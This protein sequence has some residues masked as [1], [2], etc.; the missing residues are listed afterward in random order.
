VLVAFCCVIKG[1][2]QKGLWE[3]STGKAPIHS[4]PAVSK[5]DATV[6]VGC[7]GGRFSAVDA[8][9]G[10]Q[11]WSYTAGPGYGAGVTSP[12]VSKDDAT[13]FVGAE[14]N[15]VLAFHT[16]NGTTKW[17]YN[18]SGLVYSSP[19]LSHDDKLVFIADNSGRVYALDTDK[20]GSTWTHTA[21]SEVV[22]TPL[23][24]ADGKL[25]FLGAAS[26]KLFALR[27][28]DGS[29][30]W[31]VEAGGPVFASQ[32]LSPDGTMLF[33]GLQNGK[34][35]AVKTATGAAVWSY[36]TGGEAYTPSV[37]ANGA[38][39]YVGSWDLMLHAV[40]AESGKMLWTSPKLHTYVVDKPLVDPAGTH[41]FIASGSKN[42]GELSALDATSGA[43]KWSFP[44]DRNAGVMYS[45][46]VFN[47]NCTTVYIG[48]FDTKLH[49]ISSGITC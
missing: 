48:A 2:G 28:A 33:A 25:L 30:A 17:I 36:A 9:T 45:S 27:S 3:F 10:S 44:F 49:A 40:S 4:T 38:T 37:S 34:L 42:S 19:T 35:V 14:N 21:D 20:G 18:T 26:G 11:K 13:V 43:V 29:V 24:S 22:S 31:S 23:L 16:S 12:A 6:F 15:L 7:E 5:D 39:V 47:A 8:A 41:V 1:A 32:A 46:P